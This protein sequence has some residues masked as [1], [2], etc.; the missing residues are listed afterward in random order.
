MLPV[1]VGMVCVVSGSAA[2]TPV[3]VVW[4]NAIEVPGS[5]TL[6]N[7]GNA[8]VVSVTCATAGGC[9]AGGFYKDGSGHHQAFVVSEK[10]GNWGSAI[11]VPGIET[12]NSGGDA[13]V[14]SVSCATAGNCTAAG[15]YRDG[16]LHYQAFVVSEKKGSWGSAIEVPGTASLNMGGNAR[17]NSVSCATAGACTAVGSYTDGS[18]HFQAFVVSET[19]GIWGSAIEVPGSATLNSGADA[20]VLKVACGA[21]G[22]CTAGGFYRDGSGDYQAF[23]V[24]EKNGSWGSAIEVPGT[25]TLNSAGYALVNSVSC[26]TAGSC[27]AGGYYRDSSVHYQAFVVSE[28]NGIWGSAIEVPGTASLN[29]GGNAQV[30]SVSCGAAGSCTAAGFYTDGSSHNQAFVVSEKNG[31]WGSAIEVPGSAALNAGGEADT[32]EVSCRATGNCTAGGYYREG[33]GEYQAFVVSEKN[34]SWG[35]AIEVPGTPALNSGGY[36]LVNSVSCS[37]PGNCV[38]GGFYTDGAGPQRPFVVSSTSPCLVPRLVGKT[39]SAA[40]RLITAAG[41]SLGKTTTANAKAQRG[42]VV[43]QHPK[44]GTRLKYGAKVALTLSRGK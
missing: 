5:A 20:S 11:E 26:A 16:S 4:G 12:L 27:T 42:R 24:S 29:S 23:V 18:S 22:S 41:C 39:L 38:A 15:L 7:G 6:N 40:K 33:S 21:A 25:A 1:L 36:G 37:T 35:S 32:S 31:S 10:N 34:G 14:A 13:H 19:D 9:T 43:A 28:A 44:P 2:A 30:V 3:G 8:Q 17:V